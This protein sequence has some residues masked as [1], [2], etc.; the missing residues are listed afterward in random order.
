MLGP[1]I[2]E[3]VIWW[4]RFVSRMIFPNVATIVIWVIL[5]QPPPLYK[6]LMQVALSGNLL[7]AANPVPTTGTTFLIPNKDFIMLTVS[8]LI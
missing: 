1:L 6:M 5:L 3:D 7:G 2:R 4:N 8:M